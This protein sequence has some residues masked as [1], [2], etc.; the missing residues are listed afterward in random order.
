MPNVTQLKKMTAMLILSNHVSNFQ[1]V[2]G[3]QFLFIKLTFKKKCRLWLIIL[4]LP[5]WSLGRYIISHMRRIYMEI[6]RLGNPNYANT[7]P[8]WWLSV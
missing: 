8:V 7:T 3:K 1:R 6:H 2:K 4:L 5:L